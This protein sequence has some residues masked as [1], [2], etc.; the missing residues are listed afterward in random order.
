MILFQPLCVTWRYLFSLRSNSL[1]A[2][3]PTFYH[4]ESYPFVLSGERVSY[5]SLNILAHPFSLLIPGARNSLAFF[6]HPSLVPPVPLFLFLSARE[7][8]WII[9]RVRKSAVGPDL[10]VSS[11]T[12]RESSARREGL[13]NTVQFLT[14]ATSSDIPP[15]RRACKFKTN[16]V[17]VLFTRTNFSQRSSRLYLYMLLGNTF[18]AI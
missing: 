1:L 10:I 15:A 4:E 14:T 6:S 11:R 16:A 7:K 8:Y 2:V 3:F 18:L 17:D 5:T 13:S 9:F 12:P